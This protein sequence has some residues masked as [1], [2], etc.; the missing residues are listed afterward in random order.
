[1]CLKW[2]YFD[3]VY[4]LGGFSPGDIN[5]KEGHGSFGGK[6]ELIKKYGVKSWFDS[7]TKKYSSILFVLESTP[8]QWM[9]YYISL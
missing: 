6:E 7:I 8:I 2:P 9:Y 1:M 4:C 3:L 5:R